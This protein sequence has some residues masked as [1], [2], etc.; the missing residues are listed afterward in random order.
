MSTVKRMLSFNTITRI[1]NTKVH[2]ETKVRSVE[3]QMCLFP[4]CRGDN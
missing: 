3:E 4:D 1:A 2:L